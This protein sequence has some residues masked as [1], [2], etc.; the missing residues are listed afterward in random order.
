MLPE[1]NT[2][3]KSYYQP[4]KILCPMDME[5]QKI[6]VFPNDCILYRHEFQEMHKCPKYGVSQYKVK[7]DNECSRDEN[8]KKGPPTKVLWYLPIIPRFKCLFANRD[9]AKD[10]T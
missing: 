6:H 4:K 2:L 5:Y 7:D 3:S 10:L 9:D 1:E 8:S